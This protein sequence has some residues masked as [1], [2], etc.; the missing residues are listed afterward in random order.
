MLYPIKVKLGRRWIRV[1][2]QLNVENCSDKGDKYLRRLVGVVE[3]HFEKKV[4]KLSFKNEFNEMTTLSNDKMLRDALVVGFAECV[5][6]KK[7]SSYK[8]EP[9]D[10]SDSYDSASDS[11]VAADT[12]TDTKGDIDCETPSEYSCPD[13]DFFATASAPHHRKPKKNPHAKTRNPAPYYPKCASFDGFVDFGPFSAPEK[14]EK[15]DQWIRDQLMGNKANERADSKKEQRV[16]DHHRP[17]KPNKADKKKRCGCNAKCCARLC[18]M[19]Y[20]DMCEEPIRSS[21]GVP[22]APLETGDKGDN[23]KLLQSRLKEVGAL[24]RRHPDRSGTYGSSTAHAVRAFRRTYAVFGHGD[25]NVY[26]RN[27]EKVLAR[28]CAIMH[29]N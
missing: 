3:R 13:C 7:M 25:K 8:D 15:M 28:V 10:D 27:T 9:L 23:V 26:N 6:A 1:H 21:R 4:E 16:C 17:S 20:F 18:T 14:I 5:Y 2:L 22:K 29:N 12:D 19:C 11:E 24:S